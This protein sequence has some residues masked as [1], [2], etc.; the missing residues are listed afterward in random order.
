MRHSS[1]PGRYAYNGI[2]VP[3]GHLYLLRTPN[4]LHV[5]DQRA[6]TDAA[7]NSFPEDKVWAQFWEHFIPGTVPKHQYG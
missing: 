5:E 2:P 7:P 6:A 4:L 3:S 1:L